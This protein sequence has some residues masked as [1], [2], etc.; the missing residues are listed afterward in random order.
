MDAVIVHIG[1]EP[2]YSML[3]TLVINVKSYLQQLSETTI[4]HKVFFQTYFC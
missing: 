3:K 2:L 4:N 1:K